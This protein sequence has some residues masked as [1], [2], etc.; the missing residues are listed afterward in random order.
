MRVGNPT[1]G[2]EELCAHTCDLLA[3]VVGQPALEG[4]RLAAHLQHARLQRMPLGLRSYQ[5]LTGCSPPLQQRN[6][7]LLAI[8]MKQG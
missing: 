5:H 3:L 6:K 7:T 8:T 2:T 4:G 1:R